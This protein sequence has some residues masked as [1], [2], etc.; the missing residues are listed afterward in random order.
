MKVNEIINTEI[1]HGSFRFKI[2]SDMTLY[3]HV[4]RNMYIMYV[5]SKYK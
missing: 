4:Y 3:I 2:K 5:K 1:I